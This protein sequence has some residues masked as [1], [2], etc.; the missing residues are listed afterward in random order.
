MFH[1]KHIKFHQLFFYIFLFFLPFQTRILYNPESTYIDW[2]FNYY[3]A[4]FVYLSD[5]IFLAFILDWLIFDR[6]FNVSRSLYV[7]ILAFFGLI[8]ITLFHVKHIDLGLYQALKWLEIWVLFLYICET[9]KEKRQFHWAFAILLLS[10]TVQALIGI[11]QFHVQHSLNLGFLGEYIALLGTPGLAT[12]DVSHVKHIRAYGTMPH[13]NV[14]AGFL[15]SCL[16]IGLYYVSQA[17]KYETPVRETMFHRIGKVIVSCATIIILLGIFFTFSR[18][19]WISAIFT[20]I[21]FIL[22]HVKHKNWQKALVIG[23]VGIVSCGTIFLGYRNLAV[24]RGTESLNNNSISLRETYN[25][26]GLE[27]IKKY[28]LIG[29]G[30][31]QYVPAL[32]DMFHMEPWQYQPA[33]NIY[34]FLAAELGLLGL[35]LFLI[36]LFE[37]IKNAWPK[38][39]ELLPFTLLLAMFVFLFIGLFDHYPLTIQQTRLTFFVLLGMLAATDNT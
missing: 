31:G 7:K 16:I 2:Q 25:H 30:V 18:I 22:F 36:I 11:L 14:L 21:A 23:L 38:R 6:N 19:A 9:L 8:F 12:I 20:L 3:L 4:N 39:E 17:I 15:V 28:P 34:I 37:I 24:S 1:M 26:M 13:P 32:R 5:L 35:A 33:H 29:V 10:G 27:L